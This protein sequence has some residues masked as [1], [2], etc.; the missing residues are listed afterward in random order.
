[1]ITSSRYMCILGLKIKKNICY[2]LIVIINFQV[3]V[4]AYIT[5]EFIDR[6]KRK[7]YND[8]KNYQYIYCLKLIHQNT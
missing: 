4:C 6:A 5:M 7:A 3:D 8:V 2:L 1:M